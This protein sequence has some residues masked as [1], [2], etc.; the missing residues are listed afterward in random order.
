MG[1]RRAGNV[2]DGSF[3]TP[4]GPA[5][6]L[7]KR[8]HLI[9]QL[10]HVPDAESA[11]ARFFIFDPFH[12]QTARSPS[13][14]LRPQGIDFF[15]SV[16]SQCLEAGRNPLRLSCQC[17]QLEPD[18]ALADLRI[19]NRSGAEVIQRRRDWER[20]LV[21][22]VLE[23]GSHCDPSLPPSATAWKVDARHCGAFMRRPGNLGG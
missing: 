8:E 9:A 18:I 6:G 7:P 17:F 13:S 11:C 21:L 19:T 20:Q 4:L 5:P 1:N 2:G 12:G 3:T 14:C 10:L 15:E 22:V 23:L 16:T